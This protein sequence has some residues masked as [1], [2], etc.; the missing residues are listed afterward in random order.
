MVRLQWLRMGRSVWGASV[1]FCGTMQSCLWGMNAIGQPAP[2][3]A[4]GQQSFATVP[5]QPPTAPVEQQPVQQ[6]QAGP[7]T[8]ENIEKIGTQ[9]NWVKKRDWLIKAHETNTEIQERVVQTEQSRKIYIEKYNNINAVLD[10]Y[11]KQLGMDQGKTGEL[12]DSITRY[13]EKKKKKEVAAL[14]D[15]V[16]ELDMQAKIELIE[17]SLRGLRLKLDQLK[18]DMKS[19]EDL[20]RS[21]VERV[22]RVDENINTVNEEASKAQVM[23]NELWGIIDHNKARD[24]YYELRNG[25]LE[26]IK[27]IQTYLSEDLM[28]DFDAVVETVKTQIVSTQE[29]IKKLE[30]EGIFV[31]DRAQRVK[32]AKVQD[33]QKKQKEGQAVSSAPKTLNVKKVVVL[34]WYQKPYAWL[35]ALGASFYNGWLWIKGKIMSGPPAK[36]VQSK[37]EKPQQPVAP[38][39]PPGPAAVVPAPDQQQVVPQQQSMPTPAP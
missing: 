10:A 34:A 5:V 19:V 29:Q 1:V 28:R 13:L 22:K 23:I 38:A 20:D 21:L 26:K 33:I 3:D 31:K 30:D 6:A 24:R 11:Y 32:A 2:L 16:Q 12:F 39:A 36:V 7:E 4:G 8:T 37:A 17:D 15:Q 14:S 27:N 35:V 25:S 9:G 18:L